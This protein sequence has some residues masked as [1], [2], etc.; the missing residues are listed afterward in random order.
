[1]PEYLG[2]AG[3]RDVKTISDVRV[4]IPAMQNVEYVK[5][6]RTT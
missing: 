4:S 6:S 2:S 5:G 3:T 1:M